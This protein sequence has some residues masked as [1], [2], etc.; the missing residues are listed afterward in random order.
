MRYEVFEFN[1]ILSH[2]SCRVPRTF[3]VEVTA[4][5]VLSSSYD[6]SNSSGQTTAPTYGAIILYKLGFHIFCGATF[7]SYII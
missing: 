5:L 2:Y 4:Y 7:I 6:I 3:D 1:T